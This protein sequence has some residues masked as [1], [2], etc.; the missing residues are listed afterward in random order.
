[1]IVPLQQM[2]LL[3][4]GRSVFPARTAAGEGDPAGGDEKSPGPDGSGTFPVTI[5]LR[6]RG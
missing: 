4:G 2:A 5:E 1:M 3:C 6:L